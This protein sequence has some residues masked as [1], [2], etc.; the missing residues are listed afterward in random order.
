MSRAMPAR[1]WLIQYLC[2]LSTICF[3]SVQGGE[4]SREIAASLNESQLNNGNPISLNDIRYCFVNECTIR[5]KESKVLL[6]V[7][8][9]NKTTDSITATNVTDQL[10]TLVLVPSDS[11]LAY[12]SLE[13][14]ERSVILFSS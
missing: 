14:P 8:H 10:F 9:V 12:C 3:I 1:W 2:W 13:D 6:S 5:L 7:I 11:Y 4:C